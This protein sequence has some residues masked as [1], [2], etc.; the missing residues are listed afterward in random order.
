MALKNNVVGWTERRGTEYNLDMHTKG[1]TSLL[2]LLLRLGIFV[3]TEKNCQVSHC[4]SHSLKSLGSDI[5]DH[6]FLLAGRVLVLHE[7]LEN[8]LFAQQIAYKKE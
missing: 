6:I 4:I 8:I 1:E 5:L 3:R 2:L 7:P